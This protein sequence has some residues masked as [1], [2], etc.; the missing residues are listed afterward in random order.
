MGLS[1]LHAV[2][3]AYKDREKAEKTAAKMSFIIQQKEERQ[4]AR[5]RIKIYQVVYVVLNRP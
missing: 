3:Q 4:A 5:H 2:Q 1:C